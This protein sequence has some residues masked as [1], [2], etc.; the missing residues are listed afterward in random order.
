MPRQ[1]SAATIRARIRTLEAQARKLERGATKG[2]R[3]AAALI[4]RHGLSFSDLRQAFSM[5]KGRGRGKRGALAGR[6][7]AVKYRDD[8]GNTWT[9]RGRP[10][11]WLVAAEKGG[12]RRDLFLIGA[13]KSAKPKATTVKKR[14]S[15]KRAERAAA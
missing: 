4:A 2:L 7:V 5:S 13:K 8:N 10:P 15:K 9:G 3:A 12:K 1:L 14:F 6:T 11:L